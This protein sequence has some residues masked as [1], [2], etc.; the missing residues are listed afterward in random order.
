MVIGQGGA[1]INELPPQLEKMIGRQVHINIVEVGSLT[2]PPSW[3]PRASLPS[4][5]EE[6]PS[7]AR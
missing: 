4:S 2:C 7:A 1:K 6:S 5:R 3:S